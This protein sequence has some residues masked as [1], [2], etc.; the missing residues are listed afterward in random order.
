MPH[1]NAGASNSSL[2]YVLLSPLS[3]E[4]VEVERLNS[5]RSPDEEVLKAR[6]VFQ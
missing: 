3:S 6:C 4:Q 5:L 1:S 2:V